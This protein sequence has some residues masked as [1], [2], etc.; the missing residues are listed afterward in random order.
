[1]VCYACIFLFLYPA[2][3]CF[4]MQWLSSCFIK[5]SLDCFLNWF[6]SLRLD[7]AFPLLFDLQELLLFFMENLIGNILDPFVL[8]ANSFHKLQLPTGHFVGLT[9]NCNI[10]VLEQ[11]SQW[12]SELVWQWMFA[13][14]TTQQALLI[15]HQLCYS[16]PRLVLVL[17]NP[18]HPN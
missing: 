8:R 7:F 14:D 9:T 15:T 6:S 5:R 2:L 11:K 1:M 4:L 13:I 3:S 12:T 16:L 10:S 17:Q 18:P